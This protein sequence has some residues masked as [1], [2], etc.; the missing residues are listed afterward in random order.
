[1]LAEIRFT[2]TPRAPGIS[3]FEDPNTHQVRII[4]QGAIMKTPANWLNIAQELQEEPS[5]NKKENAAPAS[6]TSNATMET[7]NKENVA[8]SG[9]E[10]N[11]HTPPS[12]PSTPPPSK[13]VTFEETPET[14]DD[15]EKQ[16]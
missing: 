5:E 1:M 16:E 4:P 12:Y 6:E 3:V 15:D 14:K 11:H 8:P 7:P 10:K 13:K 2:S 9:T